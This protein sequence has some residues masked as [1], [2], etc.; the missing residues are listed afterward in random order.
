MLAHVDIGKVAG[1]LRA[2][3]HGKVL[4]GGN[5]Q[6]IFGVV[7]LQAR[8]ISH[9]HATREEGIL[10]IG[11]LPTTPAW[12]AKDVEVGRPEVEPAHDADMALAQ[13]LHMLDSAFHADLSRHGVDTRGVKGRGQTPPAPEYSVT[14]S[15]ITPWRASLHHW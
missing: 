7:A 10:A 13:V 9:T 15:L 14:P 8:H 2:A 6:I 1:R 5:R 4:G 12:I 3:V 11:L